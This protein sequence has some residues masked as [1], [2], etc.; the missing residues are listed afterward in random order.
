MKKLTALTVAAVLG[1]TSMAGF[2]ADA[3][4]PA[5]AAAKP[6]VVQKAPVKKA[7]HKKVLHKKHA[8]KHHK[9]GMKKAASA[10]K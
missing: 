7:M 4:K 5:D 8:A 9:V 2:A 1:L 10:A 6:V 3:A